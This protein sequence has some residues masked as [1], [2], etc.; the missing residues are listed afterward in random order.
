MDTFGP[1]SG[2][3]AGHRGDVGDVDGDGTQILTELDAVGNTTKAIT[4]GIAIATAVLA[5]TAL[6]G[7]YTDAVVTL[8]DV[9]ARG[10]R[11]RVLSPTRSSRRTRWSASCS[12][13]RS[14]SC[15][16]GLPSTR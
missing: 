6:F 12:A 1:V 13:Q 3:R 10:R 9:G 5:A 15:S 7:S 16:P 4:K 14:S 11:C 2:Q 8:I